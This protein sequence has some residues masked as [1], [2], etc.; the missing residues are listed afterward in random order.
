MLLVFILGPIPV[1]PIRSMV[2]SSDQAG[3]S[4]STIW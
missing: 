4:I 3:G 2:S 1:I